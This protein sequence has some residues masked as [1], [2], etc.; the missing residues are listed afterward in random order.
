MAAALN[1]IDIFAN[2]LPLIEIE[3]FCLED[4]IGMTKTIQDEP[5][6]VSS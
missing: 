5:Q 1:V 3:N 2:D 4:L 6:L